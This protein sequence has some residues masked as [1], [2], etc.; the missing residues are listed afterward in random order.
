M[1]PK[2]L[3]PRMCATAGHQDIFVRTSF[4][5]ISLKRLVQ[6]KRLGFCS[7]GRF[8][9]SADN[10]CTLIGWDTCIGA[11][12]K[13]CFRTRPS[14]MRSSHADSCR[15][16]SALFPAKAVQSRRAARS[17]PRRLQDPK[18][19]DGGDG[20]CPQC[21]LRK[22]S[23][24]NGNWTRLYFIIQTILVHVI[25]R[26]ALWQLT[27]SESFGRFSW[28]TLCQRAVVHNRRQVIP[29]HA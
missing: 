28:R 26:V 5:I 20:R 6:Q 23:A 9:F 4:P 3:R 22:G 1:S 21:V 10:T 27:L 14:C 2:L 11:C 13:G 29:R 18:P 12:F 19:S 8:H 7:A 25:C 17:W 15:Y 24:W 16:I